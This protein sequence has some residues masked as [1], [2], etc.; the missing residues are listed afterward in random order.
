MDAVNADAGKVV[1]TFF[2]DSAKKSSGFKVGNFGDLIGP[3]FITA[4]S[5]HGTKLA[6]ANF[7]GR[8]IM[9]VGS[10]LHRSKND[11][12]V[13]GTGLKGSSPALAP[14]V[15]TLD[16][17]AVRGPITY[18]F[19]R[20]RGFDT[21]KV[22]C[23]FD[24][25]SLIGVLMPQILDYARE[26]PKKNFVVIPHFTELALYRKNHPNLAEHFISPDGSVL[27]VARQIACAE[28]VISSSLHGIIVAEALGI[29]AVWLAPVAGEDELKY[30]DYYLGTDRYHI[31]RVSNLKA[32][33]TAEPMPL[34]KLDTEAM[35]KSFPF[36]VLDS[37]LVSE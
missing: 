18:D 19:L 28:R 20:R 35:K 21:S 10:V 11:D 22:S 29:P 15:K 33:L 13:W 36:D 37:V 16:I 27:D 24:P 17:R 31:R 4:L 12:V 1:P 23:L 25:G 8:R 7:P 2:W 6:E 26:Q 32:A 34:P 5:G 9:C 30:S 14:T 3:A